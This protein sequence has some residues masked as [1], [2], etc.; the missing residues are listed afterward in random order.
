MANSFFAP[1][2][3]FIVCMIGHAGVLSH[4]FMIDDPYFL[5]AQG[6][7]NLYPHF[8]DFF[9]KNQ[10]T[11]YIP[12]N[13]LL[14]V[15]LFHVFKEP[16]PLYALNIMLFYINGLLLFFFINLISKNRE[17]ALLTSVIF[18]IHPMSAEILQHITWNIILVQFALL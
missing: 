4:P 16:S 13:F 5:N 14:N 2:L 17:I 6:T 10:S 1:I 7:S 15:S 11:H 3:L 9:I 8:I 12:F 18:C